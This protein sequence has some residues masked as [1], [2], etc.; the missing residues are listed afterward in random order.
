M[1]DA[2]SFGLIFRQLSST[3]KESVDERILPVPG[4]RMNDQSR[5]LVNDQQFLVFK[6]Y[7]EREIEFRE[8]T[9]WRTWRNVNFDQITRLEL[10][11][12]SRFFTVDQHFPFSHPSRRLGT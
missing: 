11:R 12:A 10:S 9:W 7:V 3:S 2:R 1:N 8:V 4:R 6:Y 5:W